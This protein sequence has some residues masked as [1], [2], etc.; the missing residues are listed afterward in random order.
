MSER[1]GERQTCGEDMKEHNSREEEDPGTHDVKRASV[2]YV[3]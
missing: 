3:P 2:K 1:N